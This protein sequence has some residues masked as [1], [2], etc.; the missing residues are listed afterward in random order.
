MGAFRAP[1]G[2]MMKVWSFTPSRIGT[3]STR[4]V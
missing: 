3:I 4:R 1:F 2:T